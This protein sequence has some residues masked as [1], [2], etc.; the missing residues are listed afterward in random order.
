M[1][2]RNVY[3]GNPQMFSLDSEALALAKRLIVRSLHSLHGF[4][5]T[6]PTHFSLHSDPS[7]T[8]LLLYCPELLWP[9]RVKGRWHPM[10]YSFLAIPGV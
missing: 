5:D 1:S 4:A 3:R 7:G 6:S 9:C 2:C 10:A 8:T